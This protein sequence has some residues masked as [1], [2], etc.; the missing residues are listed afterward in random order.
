[1]SLDVIRPATRLYHLGLKQQRPLDAVVAHFLDNDMKGT[2][3]TT[4]GAVAVLAQSMWRRR[5][6]LEAIALK[7][8]ERFKDTG[9]AAREAIACAGLVLQARD[10]GT[11]AVLPLSRP[12]RE[13]L[14]GAIDDV[15]ATAP[16]AVRASLPDWLCERFV[17]IGG[18]ALALSST[19]TPPQTLRVNLLK[20]DREGLI[21]ALANDGITVAP[22]ARSPVGVVVV[23]P[24]A[25]VFRTKAFH[26][27]LFE[28][29]DEG[30]QLVAL[31]G[32]AQPGERVVDG[33]AGAGGKTLAIAGQ[34]KGTGSIVALDIHAGRLRALKGRAARADAQNI[35]ITDLE[36][37]PKV[38]KRLHN[39]VDLVVVDAPCTGTGVLRRNPDTAWKLVPDDVGRLKKLQ[40]EILQRYAPLVRPGGRLVFATCSVLPEEN[41]AVVAA[42]SAAPASAGFTLRDDDVLRLLPSVDGTDGFFAATFVRAT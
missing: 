22:C 29:Q 25:D 39:G 20:T 11:D 41:D 13:R 40:L 27:G 23:G 38:L 36:D 4:R 9:G 31:H 8:D 33:C 18:E 26:D 35:R 30:S 10:D 5:R 42:F 7:L 3:R 32:G 19:A 24:K 17:A 37:N 16:L 12:D 15:L 14:V 28:M 6:L 21:M 1:M 2:P 34:M